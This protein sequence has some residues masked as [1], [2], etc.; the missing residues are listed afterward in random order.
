MNTQA[1]Q[2]LRD[3]E[4]WLLC[5]TL[6]AFACRDHKRRCEWLSE[7]RGRCWQANREFQRLQKQGEQ[8][9]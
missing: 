1:L 3:H 6:K 7:L 9:L 5:E 8:Y 4:A 2:I